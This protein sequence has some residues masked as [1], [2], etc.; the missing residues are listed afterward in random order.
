MTRARETLISD[1]FSTVRS[2]TEEDCRAR[3]GADL[4][5]L[6]ANTGERLVE[7]RPLTAEA[8]WRDRPGS[9]RLTFAQGNVLKGVRLP[10]PE[11]LRQLIHVLEC[12]RHPGIPDLIDHEGTALLQR[13]VP[14]TSIA[15][16]PWSSED[17]GS[18]GSLHGYIH[19]VRVPA[20]NP[21]ADGQGRFSKWDAGLP[22]NLDFLAERSA[23]RAQEVDAVKELTRQQP[24]T[25]EMG[26]IHKD[27]CAENLVRAADGRLYVVDNESFT[28]GPYSY[29]LART[30]YRWALPAAQQMEYLEAYA[31]HRDPQD[32]VSDFQ[33]WAL[34]TL[35]K[36]ATFRLRQNAEARDYPIRHLRYCLARLER[37]GTPSLGELLQRPPR[38]SL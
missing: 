4:S 27:L 13:W 12:I 31:R 19:T 37:A 1:V 33:Y 38:E 23:L 35:V 9:F 15:N 20:D 5:A 7:I 6:V 10:D 28:V 29:D 16:G 11:R 30:W 25:A 24:S 21:F 8:R 18:C 22:G 34:V 2:P 14:G 32:F 26:F 36:A 17:I 3:L